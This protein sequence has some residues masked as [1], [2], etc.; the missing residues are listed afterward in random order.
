MRCLHIPSHSGWKSPGRGFSSTSPTLITRSPL[1]TARSAPSSQL[2]PWSSKQISLWHWTRQ[3]IALLV[4]T[5]RPPRLVVLN[6][7]SGKQ[8]AAY[9][10]VGNADDVFYDEAH[11][12]VY[13]S[14]GEGFIDIFDQRG[15]DDYQPAAKISTANG[16]R[17]SLLVPELNRFCLA[18][19]HRQ[20]QKAEIRVYEVSP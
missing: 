1:W 13:I 16:A 7:E 9:P 11:K 14:G 6:M 10:A 20:S 19:P 17:T 12:H 15:P 8:V 18:V 4:V 2:G 3:T 5:R